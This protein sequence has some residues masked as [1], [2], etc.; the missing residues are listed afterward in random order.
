MTR[1]TRHDSF[2]AEDYDITRY[3]AEFMNSLTNLTY[4]YY[5]LVYMYGPGSRGI[6]SPRYDF[7]SVS[8]IVLGISSFLFHSTNRHTMQFADELAMLVLAWAIFH[9]MWT[10]GPSRAS[11]TASSPS[12]YE[13]LVKTTLAVFFPAFGAF[14]VYT[15]ELVYHY[16]CFLGLVALI[17]ARG[18]YLFWLRTPAFPEAKR[19]EWKVGGR[20]ALAVLVLAYV[21]WNIDL[22]FCG[23]LRAL[24]A[25]VGLPWAWLLE[26]HGWWHIMTAYSAAKYMDILREIQDE[27]GR[28]KQA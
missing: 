13:T 20:K 15:G 9:S 16:A 28:E 11:S 25:R 6:W 10:N 8:L 24:R 14:Y 12:S 17:I 18:Y 19:K 4:I 22:E 27:I 2:C 3:I 26:L 7:M 5:A 1:L 23:E 21:L